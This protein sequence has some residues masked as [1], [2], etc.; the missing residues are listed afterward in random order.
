MFVHLQKRIAFFAALLAFGASFF[1]A[2][3]PVSAATTSTVNATAKVAICGNAVKENGE[4]CD[5]ADFGAMNCAGLGFDGGSLACLAACEYSTGACTTEA[6]VV[7]RLSVSS[8]TGG[9]HEIAATGGS[10]TI[11][12]PP[13]ASDSDLVMRLF[14]YDTASSAAPLPSGMTAIGAV[15]R[16]TFI[17]R[18]GETLTRLARPATIVLSYAQGNVSGFNESSFIAYHR[19]DTN[20]SWQ[21]ISG[22]VVDT[23]ANTITFQTDAFS[24]FAIFAPPTSSSSSG[25]GGGGGGSNGGVGRVPSNDEKTK[26]VVSGDAYPGATVTLLSGG[27]EIAT[28]I[29]DE[30]AHFEI[31]SGVPNAGSQ[32][33]G[34]YA[35][36]AT[37]TLSPLLSYPTETAPGETFRVDDVFIPPS[38]L[39]EHSVVRQGETVRVFGYSAPNSEVVITRGLNDAS[40][41]RTH[42]DSQ[43][44]YMLDLMTARVQPGTYELRAQAN[45]NRDASPF[46][47]KISFVVEPK[48][49]PIPLPRALQGKRP[50]RGEVR[51]PVATSAVPSVDLSSLE[52]PAAPVLETVRKNGGDE[53][54]TSAPVP[55]PSPVR[56]LFAWVAALLRA[57]L[58]FIAS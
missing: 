23:S 25:G 4:Q 7:E 45:R 54:E 18:D 58:S 19:S 46:G 55:A 11:D 41:A 12:V 53:T 2:S 39:I 10:L 32:T 36:D 35:E 6:S 47:R 17:D 9:Q 16:I 20:G 26:I 56:R 1:D 28:A 8:M 40:A 48:P 30:N 15:Y 44:L 49:L 13:T 3:I 14:S 22:S 5:S 34:V 38:I 51:S 43:G 50:D 57:L 31:S 27:Q 29:A 24:L 21:A 52:A 33:F 42:A 37:G